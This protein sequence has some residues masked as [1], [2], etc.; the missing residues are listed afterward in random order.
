MQG[1]RAYLATF[2]LYLNYDASVQAKWVR[3]IKGY[4]QRADA[5]FPVLLQK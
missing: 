3:D 4:I 2:P 5:Q 1:E